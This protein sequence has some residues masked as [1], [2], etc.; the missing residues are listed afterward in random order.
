MTA[1]LVSVG[2]CV[3]GGGELGRCLYGIGG[4]GWSDGLV[5]LPIGAAAIAWLVK[6][7]ITNGYRI[8]SVGGGQLL[9]DV[10]STSSHP[11]G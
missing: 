9:D 7:T 6:V 1:D 3:V 8:T 5:V 10:A 4:G 11:N 2:F